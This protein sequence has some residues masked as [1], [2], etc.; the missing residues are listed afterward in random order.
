MKSK[1]FI[2]AL[3]LF[4]PYYSFCDC[5]PSDM[6]IANVSPGV[7]DFRQTNQVSVSFQ[8]FHAAFTGTQDCYY[9]GEFDYGIGLSFASR[10]L[11]NVS[12]SSST[13]P[14]NVYSNAV[15]DP[16]NVVR[17][18]QDA[19]IDS[20][21]V[22]SLPPF[23]PSGSPQFQ[24]RTFVAELGAVPVNAPPGLYTESLVLGLRARL[25]NPPAG[26]YSSFNITA[27]RGIQFI[28]EIPRLLNISIVNSGGAFDATST[29]RL[30]SFD[31]LTAGE[32]STASIVIETNVGYRLLA[33][34][35]NDGVLVHTNAPAST[36]S[37]D[38]LASGA[39]VGLLGS[40]ATP[41]VV[42][43]SASSSPAAGFDIPIEV[44]IGSLTGAELG[45]TY[46]DSISFNIEAF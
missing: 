20:H 40:S 15:I 24:T 30:M 9:F 19:S 35:Q 8:V 26:D 25:T 31:R 44:R 11:T 34:S 32:S 17:L 28:Y 10:N 39:P 14:F 6:S 37:Y 42:S 12:S 7:V 36:I 27:S 21:V 29:G 4:F 3:I 41:V 43:T 13:I 1:A 23:T 22:Y 5:L 33:S 38:F 2:I 16:N 46:R 18:A 45:G